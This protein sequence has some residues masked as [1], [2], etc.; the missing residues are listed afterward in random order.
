M[1]DRIKIFEGQLTGSQKVLLNE[2]EEL[3]NEG[4]S[5]IEEGTYYFKWWLVFFIAQ[6]I[7]LFR[8]VLWAGILAIVVG[9][10]CLIMHSRYH[11]K[12]R[13][14]AYQIMELEDKLFKDAMDNAMQVFRENIQPIKKD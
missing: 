9:W 5:Y 8:H 11:S 14:I 13:R 12:A 1:N 7:L 6:M 4:Q 3:R 10:F 2:I